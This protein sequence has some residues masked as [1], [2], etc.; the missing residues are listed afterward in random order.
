MK[1]TIFITSIL[2]TSLSFSQEKNTANKFSIDFNFGLNKPTSSFTSGYTSKFNLN[3]TDL[4]IRYMLNTKCGIKL[5]V[6][7]DNFNSTLTN[8]NYN[9]NYLRFSL[10]GIMNIGSIIGFNDS[11]FGL[12][13][14]A[15]SGFGSLGDDKIGVGKGIDDMINVIIGITPQYRISNKIS[16]NL[17]FSYIAN[18]Y[19]NYKFDYK[20][21]NTT[22]GF[23]GNFINASVGFSI[24]LGKNEKHF[25]WSDGSESINN[26]QIDSLELRLVN[27]TKNLQKSN[28]GSNLNPT[29]TQINKPSLDQL[30]EQINATQ[31]ALLDSD[32]DGIADYLDLEQNTPEGV[33]VDKDGKEIKK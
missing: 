18:I 25:D 13:L 3:H 22:R 4:G 14:H 12:L 19:Q 29:A 20:S 6:G 24:Y 31:N 7:L 2:A 27:A 9:T 16:L 30:K 23:D 11:K 5:D 26:Q 17:D 28:S 10:Q 1:K 33:K 32:K 8:Y 21:L 15:G